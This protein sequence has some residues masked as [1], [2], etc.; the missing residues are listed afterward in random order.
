MKR[1]SLPLTLCAA[2]ALPSLAAAQPFTSYGEA[3]GWN[4]FVNGATNGCFME[5]QQGD[6]VVQMGTQGGADFAFVAVYAMEELG[7]VQGDP[8]EVSFFIDGEEFAGTASGVQRSTSDGGVIEGATIKAN[9]PNFG[10]AI[11]N[12]QTMTIMGQSG[13]ST[14][15]DLS[16]TR[17]AIEATRAC[18]AERS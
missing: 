10:D 15:I 17:A 7:I 5:Q 2:L 13:N 12:K 11:A 4:I 3:E 6:L 1:H 18:Q 8:I 9:N 14:D 16:G